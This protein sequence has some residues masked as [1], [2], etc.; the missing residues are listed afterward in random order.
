MTQIKTAEFC[1]KYGFTQHQ[2]RHATRTGKLE[3]ISKGILDE[4]L[5]LQ[6]MLSYTKPK[7]TTNQKAEQ[8]IQTP[9][10]PEFLSQAWVKSMVTPTS[11]GGKVF[12]SEE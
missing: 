12:P 10:K 7:L 8:S 3:K 1:N 4:Q 5:T 11:N 9:D 2:I 6:V